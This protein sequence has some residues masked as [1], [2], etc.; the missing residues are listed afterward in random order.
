M[1][2]KETIVADGHS[3]NCINSALVFYLC[4][5]V[6]ELADSSHQGHYTPAICF[7]KL[8]SNQVVGVPGFEPGTLRL[9]SAC[10]NQLSYTPE[11]ISDFRLRISDLPRRILQSAICN[12]QSA[13]QIGG[14]E[15]IR[16]PDLQLAKLPLYQL[17]Y[18]PTFIYD[19]RQRI[20]DCGTVGSSVANCNS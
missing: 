12:R 15:G 19:L 5:V 16:T 18:S 7:G 14:A 9:S 1:I 4:V 8:F 3:A 2:T 11:S 20:G 13:I 6:K 10:S 17:S